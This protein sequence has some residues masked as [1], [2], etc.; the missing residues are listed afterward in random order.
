MSTA[1]TAT[2]A[3]PSSSRLPLAV[4]SL[5]L[6]TLLSSLGTSIANVALPTFETAFDA[7]F[8]AVQWIVLAYLLAITTLIVSVGRLGDMLGRRR[9]MLVGIGVF[10]VA[11]IACG[12]ASGL[13][14]LVGARAAQGLGAAVM[15]VLAMAFVG[16]AVPKERAGRAMGVLGTMSAVGTALGPTLG[17]MLLAASGWRAVFFV[18]APL[19]L[20]AFLLMLR[21]LPADRDSAAIR[22]AFDYAGSLVLAL[23][24]GAYAL[25]MT[26]GRGSFGPANVALLCL[27]MAGVGAFLVVESKAVSPLFRPALL[28]DRAI[29]RGFAMGALVT[30]VA[31]TTLVVGPFHLAGALH[32][33]PAAIGLVMSA[34]PLVA[35]LVGVPAGRGVDR[36]G[37]ARMTMAGLAG[38][39]VGCTAL[40]W[41]PAASGAWGYI[42][43]LVVVTA[44]FAMFQAANNTA[45]MTGVDAGQRGVASGLLNLS[46][47]LGLITGASMMGAVFTHAAGTHDITK[48]GVEAIVSGTHVTF[49]IAAAL[50]GFALAI[51]VTGQ[52]RRGR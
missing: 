30:T 40:S 32:L 46:R 15:M 41:L 2:F 11:S 33:A 26:L 25:A 19:G 10:T 49:A 39:L 37:A 5:S 4:A 42:A 29:G 3:G 38:M 7:S 31:M 44:G 9:L 12:S 52:R 16:D 24:L 48:A 45:V 1:V 17:G 50:V 23:T 6:A 34:G 27:A 14:M 35:A 8:Q 47:N 13:W 43:A 18:L 22:P 28:M 21:A 51:A 20:A 36:Y